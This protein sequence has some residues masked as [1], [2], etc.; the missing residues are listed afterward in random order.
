MSKYELIPAR[1]S[2]GQ[3]CD[4]C[5]RPDTIYVFIG[6]R[7]RRWQKRCLACAEK[8]IAEGKASLAKSS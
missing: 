4:K 2:R 3:R 7:Y 1:I 6:L 5:G 8:M